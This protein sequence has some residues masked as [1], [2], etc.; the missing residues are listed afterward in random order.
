MIDTLE[1]ELVYRTPQRLQ[2]ARLTTAP[3]ARMGSLTGCS[4]NAWTN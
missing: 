2:A 1:M 4:R 3:A